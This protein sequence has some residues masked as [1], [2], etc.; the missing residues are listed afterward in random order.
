MA[1]MTEITP[2]FEQILED[3]IQ[4]YSAVGRCTEP[5]DFEA[6]RKLI[7]EVY[8]AGNYE[9]PKFIYTAAS[10]RDAIGIAEAIFQVTDIGNAD[11]DNFHPEDMA[12]GKIRALADKILSEPIHKIPRVLDHLN[13]QTPGNADAGYYG[14]YEA[15]RRAKLLPDDHDYAPLTALAKV[16]GSVSFYVD[17]CILMDRYEE[18]HLDGDQLHNDSGPAIKFRDGFSIWSIDGVPVNEKIVMN[19]QDQTAEEMRSE[20]NLEVK[21]IRITRYGWDKY[22][23]LV[24]AEELDRRENMIENTREVL[25]KCDGMKVLY[26]FDPST[27][28]KYALEVLETDGEINSCLEAQNWLWNM[29]DADK[30]VVGRT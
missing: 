13:N 24:G 12:E 8:R 18:L 1:D 9:P 4:E 26:T 19:P 30:L 6:A 15:F 11:P 17:F 16:C 10:P 3:V 14:F 27:G 29:S 25:F 23:E 5:A 28:R 22:F 20:Q 21:R 2:E 7:P